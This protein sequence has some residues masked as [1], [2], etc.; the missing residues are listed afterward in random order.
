[1]LVGGEGDEVWEAFGEG[2]CGVEVGLEGL[3]GEGVGMVFWELDR[4]DAF[5]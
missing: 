4:G 1:M 2:A 3:V 5:L